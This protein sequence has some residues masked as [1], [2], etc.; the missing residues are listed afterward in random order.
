MPSHL[1]LLRGINVGGRN[2]VAMGDLRDL[3]SALG[4][5]DVSTY[6]QS[7][8]V[9]FSAAEGTTG[10]IAHELADAIAERLAV[11]A[12]VV[13]LTRAELAEVIAA[14]PFPGELDPRRVHALIHQEPLTAAARAAI[15]SASELAAP[16]GGRDEA[17]LAG[18]VIYLS[19][20][21]GFGRSDLAAR[22]TR[23]S[24][25]GAAGTA[26]NWATVTK[27]MELLDA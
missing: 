6:I 9:L 25:P 19:T 18:R 5:G 11:N 8:N 10:S 22:L 26:R 15:A 23:P 13:V 16:K 14:N 21:E 17:V 3:V 1:A 24:G 2:R 12:T 20:P 4:H 7:G 27:L